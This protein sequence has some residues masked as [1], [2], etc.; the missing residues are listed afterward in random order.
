MKKVYSLIMA[1]DMFEMLANNPYSLA[2]ELIEDFEVN[3][4]TV[5]VKRSTQFKSVIID[6]RYVCIGDHI[7]VHFKGKIYTPL[8]YAMMI[9]ES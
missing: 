5:S 7:T 2:W 1:R 8:E 6:N 4:H 3:G 9:L